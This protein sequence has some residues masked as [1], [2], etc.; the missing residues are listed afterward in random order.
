MEAK[1]RANAAEFGVPSEERLEGAMARNAASPLW[2]EEAE[3]CVECGACNT[4]CPTCHCFFLCDQ[5]RNGEPSR[6]RL[7]DSC[8]YRD[9]GRV[10]GGG[11]PRARLWMRLRNRFEKKFDFF[12]Q[13]A[14]FNACTGCGR[15][16]AACPARIDIRRILKRLTEDA[17]ER[18]SI[19]AHSDGSA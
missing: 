11:N 5:A 13:V 2:A 7:W 15:C 18:E 16:I 1:V 19:S 9:F 12:P 3:A 17:N 4:V 14:G 6:V 8:L 10:A